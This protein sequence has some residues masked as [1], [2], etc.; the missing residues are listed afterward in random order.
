MKFTEILPLSCLFGALSCTTAFGP[1]PSLHTFV[2]GGGSRVSASSPLNAELLEGWK[3]DGILK[4]LNNFILVKTAK[5]DGKT[6][7]GI[8]ISSKVAKTEGTVIS[9]GPGSYHADTGTP[10]PIP[11]SPGDGVIYGQYDGIEI[12]VDGEKHALIRDTD[13]L[14]KYTA[15][16]DTVDTVFPVNDAVLVYV[17]NT[18]NTVTSGG[19]LLGSTAGS[20][21]KRPSTG[22]VVKVGPGKMAADGGLM[23]MTVQVGDQVKFRDFVGNEVRIGGEEYSVVA[24]PE[25]LAKF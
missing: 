11:V 24:M 20:E 9:A 25:I 13:I 12:D 6:D 1:P 3:V 23:P 7:T 5:S 16:A 22:E 19:L 15:D 2:G 8:L 18:D 10:Y 4:P 14:V 17:E 21:S